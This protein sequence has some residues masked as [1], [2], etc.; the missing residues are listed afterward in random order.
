MVIQRITKTRGDLLLL[1]FN[2]HID[3]LFDFAA[4]QTNQVV[5]MLRLAQFVGSAFT[6]EMMAAQKAGHF[7][8]RED[9][10]NGRKPHI[11][12]FIF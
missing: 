9:P 1:S 6:V 7:K 11:L 3:K 5:M 8:L 12:A 4:L 2:V 10:V